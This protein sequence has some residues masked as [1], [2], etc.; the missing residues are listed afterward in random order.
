MSSNAAGPYKPTSPTPL[1]LAAAFCFLGSLLLALAVVCSACAHTP[2]Q[3]QQQLTANEALS[4]SI[5]AIRDTLRVA[6]PPLSNIA[7]ILGAI[8]LAGLGVWNTYLHRQVAE[9]RNGNSKPPAQ[10]PQP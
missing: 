4:N 1:Q 9:V 10:K 2:E 3:A 5:V 6:P 8:A 7:E